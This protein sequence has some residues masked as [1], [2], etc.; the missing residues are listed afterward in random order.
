M[1]PD[2]WGPST[3]KVCFSLAFECKDRDLMAAIMVDLQ[4]VL[5][6]R[7]CRD[8]YK[9]TMQ[10]HLPIGSMGHAGS[11]VALWLFTAKDLMLSKT[12]GERRKK[13]TFKSLELR[14][15]CF[16]APISLYEI[17]P[18]LGII[19][20]AAEQEHLSNTVLT[21]FLGNVQKAFNMCATQWE[22]QVHMTEVTVPPTGSVD[23]HLVWLCQ[24]L[25]N[26]PCKTGKSSMTPTGM[27][28]L[29]GKAVPESLE[30]NRDAVLKLK[31]KCCGA[32][33]KPTGKR[34]GWG[35]GGGHNALGLIP[36]LRR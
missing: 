20:I 23:H 33:A 34:Q 7:H 8:E 26:V 5:P 18:V 28:E 32:R 36:H 6:C 2:S 16:E 35:G 27:K 29:Y 9:S 10:Q 30:G 12:Q 21:R 11:D 1:D 19:I 22:G 3:W 4:E 15:T 14:N 24:Q 25:A 31:H 17:C 13:L